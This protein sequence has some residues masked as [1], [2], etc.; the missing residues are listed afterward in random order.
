[1]RVAHV[2]RDTCVAWKRV[3]RDLG[4]DVATHG[5]TASGVAEPNIAGPTQGRPY[6]RSAA[7]G[8]GGADAENA[9][10][11]DG[12]ARG[13]AGSV[14]LPKSISRDT[15]AQRP[16]VPPAPLHSWAMWA[17]L[18]QHRDE[19]EPKWRCAEGFVCG[20]RAG[21]RILTVQLIADEEA[22]WSDQVRFFKVDLA[23][24]FGSMRHL[25]IRHF[26]VRRIGPAPAL[27]VGSPLDGDPQVAGA[28]LQKFSTGAR[29]RLN[30][31]STCRWM[32]SRPD[33]V[34]LAR[35][36]GV[37]LPNLVPEC[38]GCCQLADGAAWLASITQ[39]VRTTR[40]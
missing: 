31:C 15:V 38:E 12:N 4:R 25:D 36:N 9:I 11:G 19:L 30:C 2:F 6:D 22:E 33:L 13:L 29:R 37:N 7:V 17:I 5:G 8:D 27:A 10:F 26:L 40:S 21:A 24:A 20:G 35:I 18:T 39:C 23:D 16:V 34:C 14:F 1:M 28:D 3:L 32:K